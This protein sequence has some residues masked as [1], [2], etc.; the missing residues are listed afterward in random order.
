MDVLQFLRVNP[1]Q[2]LDMSTLRCLEDLC[3]VWLKKY[4]TSELLACEEYMK[5][6]GTEIKDYE[7][8]LDNIQWE[9]TR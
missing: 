2:D 3:K 9:L 8:A 1:V 5:V 7:E 6:F 4:S